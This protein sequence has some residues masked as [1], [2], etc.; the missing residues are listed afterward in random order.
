[1]K[2]LFSFL[3]FWGAFFLIMGF[4]FTGFI[5]GWFDLDTLATIYNNANAGKVN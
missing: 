4:I 3:A 5:L 2:E 1:M